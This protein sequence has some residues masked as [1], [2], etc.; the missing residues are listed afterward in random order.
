M[1]CELPIVSITVID[2]DQ[3]LLAHEIHNGYLDERSA[4]QIVKKGDNYD[5]VSV[6]IQ[7]L[8]DTGNINQIILNPIDKSQIILA[9]QRGLFF[10]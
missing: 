5:Y 3:L 1:A 2:D 9:C 4:L 7:H 10:A 8:T 6:A